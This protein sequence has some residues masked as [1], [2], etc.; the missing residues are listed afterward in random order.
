MSIHHLI[1]RRHRSAVAAAAAVCALAFALVVPAGTRVTAAEDS[2]LPPQSPVEYATSTFDA[3]RAGDANAV[4][5][6]TTA[7]VA[8]LLL[9]SPAPAHAFQPSCE[10]AAGSTYCTWILEDQQ[11]T[12]RVG[13]EAASIGSPHAVFAASFTPAPWNVAIWPFASA[14]AA[15]NAQQSVDEGH[16]PWMLDPGTVVLFYAQSVLGW[17]SPVVE[18]LPDSMYRATDTA[19]GIAFDFVVSQPVRAG[20]GGIWAITRVGPPPPT[21]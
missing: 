2:S 21:P 6:R 16:S 1:R 15:A 9:A 12:L 18:A 8:Q 7:Q 4:I 5:E 11:L 13:N 3:W 10:G 14:E 20:E 17:T 19:S